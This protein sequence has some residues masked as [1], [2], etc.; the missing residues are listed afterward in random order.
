MMS[1]LIVKLISTLNISTNLTLSAINEFRPKKQNVI[2]TF[3]LVLVNSPPLI[4]P[5]DLENM[6]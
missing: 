1:T 3:S 5:F 2:M 6:L 4:R